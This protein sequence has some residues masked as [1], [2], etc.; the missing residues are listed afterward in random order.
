MVLLRKK[1]LKKDVFIKDNGHLGEF[2]P[3]I[4]RKVCNRFEVQN[5]MLIYNDEKVFIFIKDG[6]QNQK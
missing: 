4:G 3:A 1:T 2:D 6:I 5:S